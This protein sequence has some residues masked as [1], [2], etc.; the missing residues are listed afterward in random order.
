MMTS[1]RFAIGCRTSHRML[2]TRFSRRTTAGG[3]C[4]WN[5]LRIT[6]RQP[7]NMR[8]RAGGT[9]GLRGLR[10]EE[11][12]SGAGVRSQ[13]TTESQRHREN[14]KPF[15]FLRPETC[16]LLLRWRFQS[17]LLHDHLQVF[18]GLFFLA[19]ITQEEGRMVRDGPFGSVPDGDVAADAG[20]LDFVPAAAQVRDGVGDG[21]RR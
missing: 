6:I 2:A 11:W 14:R 5:G 18:P 9:T 19:G 16:H 13:F 15:S 12:G 1:T 3:T 17:Q 8:G 21:T 10:P 7:R 20:G 4:R